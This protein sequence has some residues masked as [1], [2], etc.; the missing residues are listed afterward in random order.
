MILLAALRLRCP[1]RSD[2][3]RK[4]ITTA[5]PL[6]VIARRCPIC[7]NPTCLD[8]LT[9]VPVL[10]TLRDLHRSTTCNPHPPAISP[11]ATPT[12]SAHP[13]AIPSATPCPQH[14]KATPTALPIALYSTPVTHPTMGL[15][16][17][18]YL[19]YPPPCCPCPSVF[20]SR[21]P[22]ILLAPLS[23]RPHTTPT[24]RLHFAQ[25][26]C[27]SPCKN[28]FTGPFGDRCNGSV[29]EPHEKYVCA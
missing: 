5:I 12:C 14:S 25:A 10:R 16:F 20:L 24:T 6:A 19:A 9:A 8:S 7:W 27:C 28:L 21:R 29:L 23:L 2:S 18:A 3:F 1:A 11:A 15:Q 4:A 22:H 13:A 17:T 26:T